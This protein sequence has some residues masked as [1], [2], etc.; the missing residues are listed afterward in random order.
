MIVTKALSRVVFENYLTPDLA[1]DQGDPFELRS[2]IHHATN[3]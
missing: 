2:L 3:Q 1:G